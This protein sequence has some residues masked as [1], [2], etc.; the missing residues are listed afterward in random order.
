MWRIVVFLILGPICVAIVW[1]AYLAKPN[2]PIREQ[3][4]ICLV[5]STVRP[6]INTSRSC[7]SHSLEEHRVSLEE[8]IVAPD[9]HDEVSFLLGFVE[10]D[11]QGKPYI[12]DQIDLMFSRIEL[13]ARYRDLLIIVYVHGWKHNATVD[14]TNVQAFRTLLS[15]LAWLESQRYLAPPYLPLG[16]RKV[17]GIYLSWRGLSVD[18][19]E[20]AEDLTFW[21]RMATAHR[22]AEGSIREVLARAK[23][24]RDAIDETSWDAIA[25]GRHTFMVTIGHSFG[26]LIVYTALSQYYL[27]RVV[28]TGLADYARSLGGTSQAGAKSRTKEIPG[29]GDLVV[30]VNPAIEAMRYE[31]IREV[32]EKRRGPAS[33]APEQNPVFVELT[34]TADTATSVFFPAGRLV[35]ATFESFTNCAER[36]EAMSSLGH[37]PAFWTHKL[38][39]PTP[40]AEDIALPPVYLSAEC[41]DFA[42]FNAQERPNGYLRPGWQR[43][44]RTGAVLTQLAQSNYDPNDPFWIITT[45][46]SMIRSHNDIQAP[47]FVDFLRQFLDDMVRASNPIPCD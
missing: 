14:D 40:V 39:G 11:D 30:V 46:Q 37:Y 29:Y 27:D 21:N 31:P 45:D 9:I 22:I 1:V 15:H 24:L 8:H 33:F 32:L 13:E 12:R 19:G 5:R 35:D 25:G 34:S 47:I 23:A 20:V 3:T 18:A 10:F 28:Q 26:G 38:K 44:Y 17:V 4:S 7:A 42:M 16:P 6:D 36:R 43:R 41:H 2:A